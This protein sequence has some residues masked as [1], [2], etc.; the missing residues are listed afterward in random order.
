M[1]Q[2]DE[3]S[4]GRGL[5]VQLVCLSDVLCHLCVFWGLSHDFSDTDAERY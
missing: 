5:G 1:T 4:D 2:W 3:E